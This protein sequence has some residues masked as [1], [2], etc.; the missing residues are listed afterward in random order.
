MTILRHEM[1][2]S[3][4]SLGIW[5]AAIAFMLGICVLIYPEMAGQMTQVTDIFADMGSFTA[6]FGMDQVNFGEFLG[7]FCVE[8]GNVLGLGGALFAAVT[9]VTM[10][11]KEEKDHT[12]EFLLTHPVSRRRIITE[13]LLAVLA[14]V[15]ILNLAVAAV[16]VGGTLAIGEQVGKALWLLFL[17]YFL[18]QV[19]IALIT[20][21]ISAFLRSGGMAVG[22]GLAFGFYFLNILA[23]LTE[24]AAFLKY[25]TPFG[26]TDG[27]QIVKELAL[28]GEYLAVGAGLS[29]VAI[30]V[31]YRKYQKKDI[32]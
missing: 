27:G 5:T 13:K 22:L 14:Q 4:V 15:L 26:Y 20:F 7:Y 1:K 29:L 23:N 25:I 21:G 11:A 19:E 31:A 2:R 17:A 12:A 10:L 30:W 16:T 9:G 28:E 8:C 32:I 6:A 18:L 24:E 3:R